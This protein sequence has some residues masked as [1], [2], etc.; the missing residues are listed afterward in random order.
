[1]CFFREPSKAA[2][3]TAFC[4]HFFY[5]EQNFLLTAK[6]FCSCLST[7]SYAAYSYTQDGSLLNLE[8][9]KTKRNSP[10]DH[11]FGCPQQLTFNILGLDATLLFLCK[12]H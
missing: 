3:L 4:V 2:L 8:I 1:M 5:Q 6:L 7:F 10:L 12:D 11:F 9:Y